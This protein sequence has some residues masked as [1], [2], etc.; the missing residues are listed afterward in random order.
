MLLQIDGTPFGNEPS[1]LGPRFNLRVGVQYR[2]YAK[3]DGGTTNYDGLGHNASD[4]N[5][6]RI[7]AW[8]AL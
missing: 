1:S 7:F 3:F 8:L 6:L 2:I 5:T 4:N